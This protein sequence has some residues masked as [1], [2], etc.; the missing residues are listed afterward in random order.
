M[1]PIGDEEKLGTV[2]FVDDEESILKSIQRSFFL[3]DFEVI[4]ALG[5]HRAL[6]I[7]K[8]QTVDIVISDFRMPEI[9][10]LQLLKIVREKYPQTSRVILSGY[11]E[12]AA[13][14]RSLTSGVTSTYFAKPWEDKVLEAR[15]LHILDM[16]QILRS[17]ELLSLVNQIDQLPTLPSLYQE[18]M[19]A[20][21]D[22]KPISEIAT[23]IKKNP[24]VAT[25]VLQVANSA[26]YGLKETTSIDFAMVY[27]GLNPLKD[28]VL[29][30]TLTSDMN[31][32]PE[33][34]DKLHKIFNHSNLVNRYIPRFY[35]FIADAPKYKPFPAVGL[36][37]D[38]G[39]I[40]MLQYFPERFRI[41][42]S[43]QHE[44]P[45]LSFWD[46]EIIS[47]F[48]GH[49]HTELGAYFLDWWNLP[50]VIVEVALFHHTSDKASINYQ[51]LVETAN[52]VDRLVNYL[53]NLPESK[54]PDLEALP[55]ESISLD[56]LKEMA[57]E[58]R[59][60]MKTEM[61]VI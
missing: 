50:E 37:H 13:V 55:H 52:Y 46:A 34:I 2:L 45:M 35:N 32:T 14:L 43:K 12:H 58:I 6:E 16:R 24:S 27:I 5:A 44:N 38:I 54:E 41:I 15:I 42:E 30:L 4:T 36:T 31:W 40:I 48:G 47:G 28:I 10:G 29:T 21:E 20:V 7:L 26:F 33:Q 3:A 18:F 49:T 56:K 39:K 59:S 25:K 17:Q 1:K 51:V 8:S 57:E 53:S 11:V 19:A 22:E 23:I 61:V 9:D 60:E